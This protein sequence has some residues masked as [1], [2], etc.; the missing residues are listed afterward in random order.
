MIKIKII[1]TI[2]FFPL[3][4]CAQIKN[5][6]LRSTLGAETDHEFDKESKIG[7]FYP[8]SM[9]VENLIIL[10]KVWGFLKYYHPAIATGKYNWDYEL[11]RIMPRVLNCKNRNDCVKT[12][13]AWIEELGDFRVEPYKIPDSTEV[14]L[15]PNLNWINKNYLSNTLA[16]KLNLIKDAKRSNDNYYLH[17]TLKYY[18]ENEKAYKQ[19]QYEDEGYRLL[20]LFRFWNMIEYCY[21][22]KNLIEED[23]DSVLKRYVIEFI[24]NASENTYK[25]T[26][27][28]LIA[29]IHDSH[30]NISGIIY[31]YMT[32]LPP[33]EISFIEGKTVVTGYLDT[34]ILGK[35]SGFLKGDIIE[36]IDGK[37]VYEL[38]NEMVDYIPASNNN[39]LLRDV[40]YRLIGTTKDSME[41][42]YRRGSSLIN[43]KVKCY[44]ANNYRRLKKEI[45]TCFKWIGDV[46][47]LYPGLIKENNSK[48]L[49]SQLA[50]SKGL[51]IDFRCYPASSFFFDLCK[52]LLPEKT[53]FAKSS[54]NIIKMPGLFIMNYTQE[55]GK[56][57][58][59]Y[60]KGKVVI[61][62]NE[63]TQSAA[64]YQVMAIQRAPNVVVI[65]SQTA[66]ADG[67]VVRFN[68]PGGINALY[69]GL[70]IYYSDGR[71]T[72]R[73]GIVPNIEVKPT[74]KGVLEDRDELLEK[75][76]ELINQK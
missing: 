18:F 47:Y 70:G 30:A 15:K 72:Q 23:W 8:D 69:S 7:L 33:I 59:D 55:I 39:T 75:A 25:K 36:K 54:N 53:H 51:I 58:T 57:N 76:I 11:F 65:G 73:I 17:S 44:K 62:V 20:C 38:V 10:C 12:L 41:F 68:L 32:K 50:K 63:K 74:I 48:E 29:K 5:D 45:D 3:L 35:S 19:M 28:S 14:K 52:F 31:N 6:T 24:K 37:T 34:T 26:I 27:L 4:L 21:P 60:Y 2:I 43:R 64:E 13:S 22:Y 71:E 40:K 1:L 67:N 49:I 16:S 66:G 46:A 56:K 61:I 42:E 9:Q